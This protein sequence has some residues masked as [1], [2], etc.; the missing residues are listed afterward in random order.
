MSWLPF[1]MGVKI[2]K[3]LWLL[4][5]LAAVKL[6][7]LGALGVGKLTEGM[8][9]PVAAVPGVA[10]AQTATP[11]ADPA[12]DPATDPATDPNAAQDPA[13]DPTQ[14]QADAQSQAVRE[15]GADR[16]RVLSDTVLDQKPAGMDESDWQV[17][18]KRE[19][20]LA[21]KERTLNE[22]EAQLDA[23]TSELENLNAQLRSLLDEVKSEKDERVQKLI[24]A[25]ANMKAKSA[26]AVL[27]TMNTDLAVKILA[28]LGGRQAGEILGFIETR[29]A[30][31]L[32]EALT[33]LRVPFEG[34]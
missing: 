13:Q 16:S 14:N 32:S 25:Y 21:A 31:Q 20:E 5:L 34:Q 23:K 3:A 7:V 1:G 11:A 10:E 15:A 18:K 27:E 19:E 6:T 4:L 26:A 8:L 30:A 22:L 12:A 9:G 33:Q 17:L 29:R 28:G 24:K 2:S